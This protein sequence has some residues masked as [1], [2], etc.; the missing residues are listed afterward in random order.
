[1]SILFNWRIWLV[2]G[3]AVGLAFTHVKAFKGGKAAV[4]A[5]WNADKLVQSE[6]ARLREKAIGISNQGVDRALQIDKQKRVIA[7]RATADSLRSLQAELAKPDDTAT[8]SRAYGTGGLEREL[9]GQCAAT[10]A[11]LAATADRLEGKVVGLQ[12]YARDVCLHTK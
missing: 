12:S 4:L 9:L 10:L 6:T 7:D 2:V 11:Q 5:E 3:L 1:M 8:A